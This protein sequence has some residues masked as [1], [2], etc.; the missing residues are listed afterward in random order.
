MD[1]DQGDMP[2]NPERPLPWWRRLRDNLS[3]VYPL[4]DN[5]GWVELNRGHWPDDEP[6]RAS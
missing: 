3:P 2:R 5:S 4:D 1:E 6:D